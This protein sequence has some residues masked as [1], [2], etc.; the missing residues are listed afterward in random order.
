M[1]NKKNLALSIDISLKARHTMF[2]TKEIHKK[3]EKMK[4]EKKINELKKVISALIQ[5]A[6][7]IG[8]LIAIIKMIIQS[9]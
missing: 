6:L 3:G 9:I 5:L 1:K 2:V 7:E 4:L 8:T